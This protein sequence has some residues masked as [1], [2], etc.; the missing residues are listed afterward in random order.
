[1]RASVQYQ[2]EVVSRFAHADHLV[3]FHV[4]SFSSQI[5]LFSIASPLQTL[6]TRCIFVSG[7]LK[8]LRFIPTTRPRC[9]DLV[10]DNE[11]NSSQVSTNIHSFCSP[12]GEVW[13]CV[14]CL[15]S[16]K[17]RN[18][19]PVLWLFWSAGSVVMSC[20]VLESVI[21]VFSVWWSQINYILLSGDFYY[22]EYWNIRLNSGKSFQLQGVCV[23]VCL[24]FF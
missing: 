6:S 10:S 9:H 8:D 16:S 23:C 17:E 24:H 14:S 11:L 15:F 18:N 12:V 3:S 19:T 7:L 4:T 22:T 2:H 5:P 1:M 20:L 21:S 13:S